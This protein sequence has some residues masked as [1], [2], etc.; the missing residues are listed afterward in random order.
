MID[1]VAQQMGERR[2]EFFQDIAIDLGF[3]AFDLQPHLLAEAA[4]Q[5]ADHAHLTGQHVR[6]GPHAA[7]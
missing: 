5:I 7:G 1:S 3:L 4:A 6:K 2:F